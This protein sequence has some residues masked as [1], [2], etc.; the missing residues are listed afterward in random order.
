MELKGTKT[1]KNLWA[2]FAGE[3]QARNKYTYFASAAKKEGYEQISGLF[4]ETAENERE[5]AK[6]WFKL[7]N[8]IGDTKKNLE[9]A[10]EGEHYEW[11]DMY[12]R[13]EQ[14]AREE[15]FTAIANQ[16]KEVAEV[17]EAHEQRYR[18]LLQ[19]VAENKVF[20][21]DKPVVWKCRNCGYLHEGN[22][23]PA[24]CPACAH[25]KAY[26]ERKSENY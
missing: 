24:A 12:K 8:G 21:E 15:G 9:I 3:S 20:S 5:H 18:K 4:L 23:A 25:P 1:E 17:E 7:L 16:F 11:T 10:A 19:N 26:F 2:A 22:D 6:L 14:E 13:M